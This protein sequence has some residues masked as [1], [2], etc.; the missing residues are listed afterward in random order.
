MSGKQL[1][2]VVL[3]DIKLS[4]PTSSVSYILIDAQNPATRKEWDAIVSERTKSD[5]F[6]VRQN[7]RLDGLEGTFGDASADGKEIDFTNSEGKVSKLP[8]GRFAALLYN[9]RLE[10][11]I[12]PTVCRIVDAAGN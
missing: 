1:Q 12:A 9:N 6:F 4:L 7:N 3:P 2:L 8:V 10:G 11:N 5:R